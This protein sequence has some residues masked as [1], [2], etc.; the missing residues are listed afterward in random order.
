MNTET[1]QCQNCKL[2]FV[3][4]PDDF[5]FYEKIHVPPPTW[6]PEC[7]MIRRFLWRNERALYP[8][9]CASSGKQ[10]ISCFSPTSGVPVYDRDIWWSDAWDPLEFGRSYD[11]AQPFFKQFQSL[12][13]VV[14]MPAV[15]NGESVNSSY[16]NHVGWLKNCYLLFASL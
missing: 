14:P 5:A 11:F 12:L 10:I 16:N 4:E 15:F 8:R 13:N 7:R 2:N 9:Q 1:R 6:C 3:I